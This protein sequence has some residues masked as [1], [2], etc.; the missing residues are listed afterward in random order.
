MKASLP[1][2]VTLPC[3]GL[4][5]MVLASIIAYPSVRVTGMYFGMITLFFNQVLILVFTQWR[6]LTGGSTGLLGIP[7]IG[8]VNMFGLH[9]DL[10]GHMGYAYFV[11][12]IVLIS[13]IFMYRIDR[14]HLGISWATLEQDES[15]ARNVGINVTWLKVSSFCIG[16][17]FA[18][19]SGA[20]YAHYLR[21]INPDTFGMFPSIYILIY[22]VFGGR[23][24][25][26]GPI[27]GA[28]VLTLVPQVFAPLREYQPFL[29]VAA[30][31]IVLYAMPG[32]V[33]DVP[34]IIRKRIFKIR[35]RRALTNDS[36]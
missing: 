33:A 4:V 16:S 5:S 28:V 11:F 32:G 23:K 2:W 1:I 19:I 21:V 22:M 13:M 9:I 18:G 10:G 26:S 20:L 14:S 29:F 8:H 12:I 30:L 3:A 31:Y 34:N 7:S 36:N 17:F 27:I 35:Q 6:A 25:F 24:Y 15:A